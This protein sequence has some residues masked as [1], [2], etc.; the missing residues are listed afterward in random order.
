LVNY[1]QAG[2]K[3]GDRRLKGLIGDVGIDTWGVVVPNFISF[4]GGM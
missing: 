2:G 4:F 1:R 3:K